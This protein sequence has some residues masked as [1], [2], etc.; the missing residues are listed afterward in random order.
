M[1][2]DRIK[3]LAPPDTKVSERIQTWIT[4]HQQTFRIPVSRADK[5]NFLR[6]H[7]HSWF[8][9]RL[10]SL[11]LNSKPGTRNSRLVLRQLFQQ[12]AVA[13]HRLTHMELSLDIPQLARKRINDRHLQVL[14]QQAHGLE[15]SPAGAQHVNRLS[16]GML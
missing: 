3:N 11:A 5:Y 4:E 7:G 9:F 12:T 6:M 1:S 8:S 16:I 2:L 13:F 14:F 10:S 15:E